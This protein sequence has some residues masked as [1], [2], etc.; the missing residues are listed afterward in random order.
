PAI[1]LGQDRVMFS[2]LVQRITPVMPE[3]ESPDH[4]TLGLPA[5][6]TRLDGERGAGQEATALRAFVPGAGA[7]PPRN[8]ED[9]AWSE[10]NHHWSGLA[11]LIIGLLALAERSGRAPWARNWP[12]LF[13]LL[14]GFLFLRSDPET[15]PLGDIGLLESLRDPE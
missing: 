14:A 11:V 6:Q 8:A 13:L 9:I 10:Y 7:L 2:E 15:W 3:L 1:D 4:A 12:L 5:L